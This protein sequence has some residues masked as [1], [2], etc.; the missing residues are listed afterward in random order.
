MSGSTGDGKPAAKNA[1]K[2]KAGVK[3]STISFS[4]SR[5]SSA[6]RGEKPALQRVTR[7]QSL[8]TRLQSLLT[9]NLVVDL[10]PT[11]Q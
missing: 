2:K 8:L 9:V 3:K 11:T 1:A 5:G 7:L 4:T 10:V 6:E